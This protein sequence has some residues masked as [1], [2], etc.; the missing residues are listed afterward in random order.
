MGRTREAIAPTIAPETSEVLDAQRRAQ[1]VYASIFMSTETGIE[2]HS[3]ADYTRPTSLAELFSYRRC[4]FCTLDSAHQRFPTA[5][6][7]H[8]PLLPSSATVCPRRPPLMLSGNLHGS[9]SS[10]V[11]PPST[12]SPDMVRCESRRGCALCLRTGWCQAARAPSRSDIRAWSNPM[13]W[14]SRCHAK[15]GVAIVQGG[16]E[17]GRHYP[18]AAAADDGPDAH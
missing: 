13:G 2:T 11:P 15:R 18:G 8:M 3:I 6:A 10:G 4:C 12:R 1:H 16:R 5:G 9:R 17:R 7:D 14:R